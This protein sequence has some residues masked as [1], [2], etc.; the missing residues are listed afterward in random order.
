MFAAATGMAAQQQ[1]LDVVANNLAN[2]DVAGFKSAQAS[3]A[4]IAGEGLLGTA[5]SGVRTLFA[6]GKL[7]KTGG[8]FDVAIDGAG[9]FAVERD[10]QR[11]Y[12]RAG[13]FSRA[14]DGSLRN[15]DGWQLCDIKIPADAT[16]VS[17]APDGTVSVAG[18]GNARRGSGASRSRRFRLPSACARSAPRS[19]CRRA[20]RAPPTRS[21][22]AASTA[23]NSPSACSRNR[24]SRSSSR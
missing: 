7:M 12:T 14:S 18:P 15:T 3:F 19:S 11:A 21:P 20:S 2:A 16:D 4:A 10:G 24:T 13:S 17:V 8:P 1:T 22:P 5:E 9:F 23:R 6:Q